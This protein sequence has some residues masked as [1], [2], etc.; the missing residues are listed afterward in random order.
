MDKIGIIS[1]N[2]VRTQL[3]LSNRTQLSATQFQLMIDFILDISTDITTDIIT[4]METDII[5]DISI[6]LLLIY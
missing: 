2:W 5:T 4:D 3:N 6:E 1:T